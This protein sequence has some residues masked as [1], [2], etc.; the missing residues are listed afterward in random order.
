MESFIYKKGEA[1]KTFI[2]YTE[3]E[4]VAKYILKDGFKFQDSFHKTAEFLDDEWNLDAYN[5]YRQ[6]C[7]GDNIII[8]KI[9]QIIYDNIRGFYKELGLGRIP[10]IETLLSEKISET[11]DED[12]QDLTHK[13]Y[14]RFIK[15]YANY[16]KDIIVENPLFKPDLSK[17]EVFHIIKTSNQLP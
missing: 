14:P 8:I 3:D 6:K 4:E 11:L 10:P 1:L 16:V 2:H 9:P 7:Y 15:G 13:L 17:K 5:H 12:Q